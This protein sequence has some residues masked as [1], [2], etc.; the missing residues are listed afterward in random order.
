MSVSSPSLLDRI[1]A[2]VSLLG[3]WVAVA[4]LAIWTAAPAAPM[5]AVAALG[6]V[7]GIS[8]RAGS[9]RTAWHAGLAVLVFTITMGFVAHRQVRDVTADWERYWSERQAEVGQILGLRLESRQVSAEAAADAL[10]E[11][12]LDPTDQVDL[13]F[14]RDLRQQHGLSALALYDAGGRLILWD[15]THWGKVPEGVQG[16]FL[17][18]TYHD[19]PL[20][21]YLYVTA[22]TEDGRVA[23]AADLLRADLPEV[24]DAGVEDF[25]GRFYADVGERVRVT[26]HDPGAAEGV[27]DL[28][29]PDRRLMSVVVDRPEPEVRAAEILDRWRVRLTVL[30]LLS[31]GL[32]A[33]GCPPSRAVAAGGAGALVVIAASLPLGALTGV[34]RL[35]GL[36][37][38]APG[39]LFSISIGRAALVALAACTLAAVARI[40]A[41]RLSPV[42]LGMTGGLAYAALLAAAASRTADQSNDDAVC[43]DTLPPPPVDAAVAFYGLP[44]DRFTGGSARLWDAARVGVPCQLHFPSAAPGLEGFDDV[45]RGRALLDELRAAAAGSGRSHEL[46]E[47][48]VRPCR[49]THTHRQRER[50]SKV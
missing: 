32:L 25:A 21:G 14:V 3:P 37:L 8:H 39:G 18:H 31:W 36:E 45:A 28:S 17:R 47:Y 16:G 5:L 12:A 33:V 29:L 49:H 40:P 30:L 34:P 9:R 22:L 41:L 1:V 20:F 26:Q 4:A 6:V 27:W 50:Q 10:A 7:C 38:T 44:E 35:L 46:H 24:L 23:M 11:K 43:E 48:L 13:E 15:G 2:W 42:A 19:R